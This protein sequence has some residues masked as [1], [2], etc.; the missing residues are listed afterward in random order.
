MVP[1]AYVGGA[2]VPESE[3]K[4]SILDHA[5]LYGDGI[6]ETAFAWHG[7]IFKLDAHIERGFRSKTKWFH[8]R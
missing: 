2:F 3:A 7:R 8:D 4:I 1:V 6:F 5:V